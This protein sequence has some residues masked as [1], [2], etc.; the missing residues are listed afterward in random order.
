MRPSLILACCILFSVSL[1]SSYEDG[2]SN[3]GSVLNRALGCWFLA[4]CV[5]LNPLIPVWLNNQF[6][7]LSPPNHRHGRIRSVASINVF[8]DSAC[9]MP[10]AE[11]VAWEADV[12]DEGPAGGDDFPGEVF[13]EKVGWYV[14][15][16]N[17]VYGP[18]TATCILH[19][20]LAMRH[21]HGH[22]AQITVS[23]IPPPCDPA[24]RSTTPATWWLDS[25]CCE[26]E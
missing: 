13:S 19:D 14:N 26:D 24:Q 6:L 17:A 16:T 25:V 2:R 20:L 23:N 3:D 18:G 7:S 5:Q 10:P 21:F 8:F 1:V 9:T 12:I 4:D 15:A 11:T 22:R